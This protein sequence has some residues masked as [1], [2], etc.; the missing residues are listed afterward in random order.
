MIIE[1]IPS[2]TRE[3]DATLQE[4]YSTVP[5]WREIL[6]PVRAGHTEFAE[7]LA[8]SGLL[9]QFGLSTSTVHD[10]RDIEVHAFILGIVSAGRPTEV[11][12]KSFLT[13]ASHWIDDF[14]DG[15]QQNG[16]FVQLMDDRHDL[17][18]ALANMGAAGAVGFAMAA[19][20][21]HPKAVFRALHRML[22]GGLVQRC[23]NRAQRHRLV[24]EYAD[25]ATLPIDRTLTRRIRQLQPEAYWT[26]NKTVLELLSA[27]EE[28]V[29]LSIA[30]SWNLVYAPAL[31]YEDAEEERERGELSFEDDEEPRLDEMVAMVRLGAARLAGRYAQDSLELQQLRFAA[32]AL[33]NLPGPILNEYR[34]LGEGRFSERVP[35]PNRDVSRQTGREQIRQL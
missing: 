24:E 32:L 26:T 25:L 10:Y 18:K 22:Y 29:D 27:A 15:D 16:N 1:H 31:Y 5:Q 7:L 35:R 12:T 21:R 20:A 4:L 8:K 17:A 2:R 9:E 6:T 34:A 3:G 19:R 33:P 30:E 13:Y 14:F 23:K 28:V 11:R